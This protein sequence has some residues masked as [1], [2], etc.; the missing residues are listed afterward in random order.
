MIMEIQTAMLHTKGLEHQYEGEVTPNEIAVYKKIYDA[1]DGEKA[2]VVPSDGE[3]HFAGL[4]DEANG[5]ELCY[6]MEQDPFVGCYIDQREEFDMDYDAGDYSS[7][8]IFCLPTSAVEI[9][10]A[11]EGEKE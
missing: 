4:M 3:Y 11:V 5:K 1:M 9:I 8:G 10:K 6:L 7:D 2:I